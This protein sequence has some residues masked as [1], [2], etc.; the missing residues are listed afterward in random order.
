MEL[1]ESLILTHFHFQPAEFNQIEHEKRFKSIFKGLTIVI[2]VIAISYCI[3]AHFIEPEGFLRQVPLLDGDTATEAVSLIIPRIMVIVTAIVMVTSEVCAHIMRFLYPES[4]SVI[5]LIPVCSVGF[6]GNNIP[7]LTLN[8]SIGVVMLVKMIL[9]MIDYTNGGIGIQFCAILV[10][11]LASNKKARKHVMLRMRQKYDT[12]SIG[13]WTL[14]NVTCPHS[15]NAV[16]PGVSIA[17]VPLPLVPLALVP[18]VPLVPRRE[19]SSA[20]PT[21]ARLP[22]IRVAR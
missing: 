21:P 16:D 14:D 1:F 2:T 22:K 5:P 19:G 12:M 18:L 13:H 10:C 20:L 8:F 6:V 11:L 17:L 9:N 4:T 3:L 15:D 7:F